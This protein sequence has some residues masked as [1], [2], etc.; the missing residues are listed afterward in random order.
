MT[1]S[2]AAGLEDGIKDIIS[3]MVE[4]LL[5]GLRDSTEADAVERFA[6]GLKLVRKTRALALEQLR[7]SSNEA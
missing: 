1:E 3:K 5:D 6:A 4:T 2:E 7:K